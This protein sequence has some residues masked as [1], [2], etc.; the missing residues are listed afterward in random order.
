MSTEHSRRSFL[1]QAGIG[2]AAGMALL[3]NFGTGIQAAVA[4][5]SLA[6]SPSDLKITKLS[7]AFATRSQRRMFV[8]L[9]TN[10][11]ITGYGE[12]TDAVIGGYYLSSFLG[13]QLIGKSPL[14]VNRLFEDMRRINRDAVFSGAQGGIVRRGAV[15][16]RDCTVGPCRQGAWDYP[17][18]DCWAVSF[19][20]PCTCTRTLG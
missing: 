20:M 14:D 8:K 2:G 5:Q 7:T 13:E 4:S 16:P 18:T 6:S 11:G 17:S 9:E 15:S 12:G 3:A 19:G 10:Q 1:K